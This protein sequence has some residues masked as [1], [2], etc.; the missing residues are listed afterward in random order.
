[1]KFV[2]TLAFSLFTMVLFGSPCDSN[3]LSV[4]LLLSDSQLCKG[5]YLLM[6]ATVNGGI[7]PY[8]YEWGAAHEGNTHGAGPIAHDTL[9]TVRVLDLGCGQWAEAKATVTV[10]D[11]KAAFSITTDLPKYYVGSPLRLLNTSSGAQLIRLK[12]GAPNGET[13]SKLLKEQPDFD[14]VFPEPGTYQISLDVYNTSLVRDSSLA[15]RAKDTLH[16]QVLDSPT[17]YIPNAFAPTGKGPNQLFAGIGN[18]ITKYHMSIYG[19]FGEVVFSCDDINCAWDGRDKHGLIMQNRS[20]LYRIV[21]VQGGI[22][23]EY[24][25]YV[26]LLR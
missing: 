11:L 22:E 17:L 7:G 19:R 24:Q 3:Q 25:G 20:Y 2:L 9:L 6:E 26:S 23:R 1:M 8:R 18:D 13:T 16:I 14:L 12:S 5:D 21:T 10:V 15:C 4:Q